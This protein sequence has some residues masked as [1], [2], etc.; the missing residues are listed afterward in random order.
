MSENS[1]MMG[2][3]MKLP[4]TPSEERGE[5]LMKNFAM[6][7]FNECQP[8][9]DDY[10][11]ECLVYLIDSAWNFYEDVNISVNIQQMLDVSQSVHEHLEDY[12]LAVDVDIHFFVKVWYNGTD[13]GS[14]F[15]EE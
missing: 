8:Y 1:M 5:W 15:K 9:Y 11:T 10:K 2:Y 3:A 7:K 14:I 4:G 12:E 6:H 13:A